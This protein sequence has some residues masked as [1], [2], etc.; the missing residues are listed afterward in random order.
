VP[1]VEYL[2]QR[3][4]NLDRDAECLPQWQLRVVE[5][6]QNQHRQ[7]QPA[8]VIENIESAHRREAPQDNLTRRGLCLGDVAGNLSRWKSRF[9]CAPDIDGNEHLAGQ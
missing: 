4:G 6:V 7:F 3:V 9:E 8:D 5:A 1:S 2:D